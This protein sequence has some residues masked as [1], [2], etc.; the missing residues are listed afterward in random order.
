MSITSSI[1]AGISGLL[2]YGN[3]MSI[4]GNNVANLNTVGFKASRAEFADLLSSMDGAA[5]IGRGVRLAGVSHPFLQGALETTGKVTDLAIQG[6]GLFVVQDSGGDSFYS[7]AGQ[8]SL[9]GN[10]EMV[11]PQG[12]A[13][14]GFELDEAGTVSAELGKIVLGKDATLPATA[15]TSVA[16]T[17]NLDATATAPTTDFPPDSVGAEDDPAN[18]FGASNFSAPISIFDSL[19]KS[20]D[21]FFLFRKETTT[22][23][24][25]NEVGSAG[26]I[27]WKYRVVANAD[28]ITGGTAGKLSQVSTEGTLTFTE[29]GS[30][31][32]AT[33]TISDIGAI[34]W[35]EITDTQDDSG[36]ESQTTVTADPLTISAADLSFSGTTQFALPSSVGASSQDGK[37]LGINTGFEIDEDGF[38]IGKF[39]NGSNKVLYRIALAGFPSEEGLDSIGESLFSQSADS[40]EAVVGKPGEDGLGSMISGGL[41]TS[42]VDLTREF[43]GLITTQRAFQVNSRVI[44]VAD[45]MY[46]EAVNLKR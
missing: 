18:W 41:E 36:T 5:E 19:G 3:S 45:R 26:S 12:F 46:E 28:E 6:S 14:Q 7:R 44:T 9:N 20:H 24:G 8:F 30:L 39:S 33:S 31:D 27:Q 22:P 16:L 11:N 4:I 38:I 2:S 40:G 35:A 1:Y 15:T 29:T 32:E 23:P 43:L 21:L 42:T 13:L 10:S 37:S 25:N 17:M 34:T